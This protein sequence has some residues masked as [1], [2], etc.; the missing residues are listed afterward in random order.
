MI[1][2]KKALNCAYLSSNQDILV[3]KLGQGAF[4]V[5]AFVVD[6]VFLE[7]VDDYFVK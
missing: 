1:F 4:M 2:I 5:K 3:E 7:A 6:E